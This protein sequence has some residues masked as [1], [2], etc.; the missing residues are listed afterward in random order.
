MPRKVIGYDGFVDLFRNL[1]KQ[2]IAE[3]QIG[4]GFIPGRR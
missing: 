4:K 1:Q 2:G 3:L